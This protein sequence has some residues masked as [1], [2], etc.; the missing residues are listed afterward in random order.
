[1]IKG[2]NKK[3]W[4]LAFR[5]GSESEVSKWHPDKLLEAY[6]ALII[7]EKDAKEGGG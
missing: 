2:L 4:Q 3:Y 6:A 5:I 1:M 7:L